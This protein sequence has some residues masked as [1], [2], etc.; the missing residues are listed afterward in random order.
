MPIVHA[1]QLEG[2]RLIARFQ[3]GH[4]SSTLSTRTSPNRIIMSEDVLP[5]PDPVGGQPGRLIVGNLK[6][7]WIISLEGSGETRPSA[8]W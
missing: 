5:P 7:C 4:I 1:K 8:K 3:V 6:A 2:Y